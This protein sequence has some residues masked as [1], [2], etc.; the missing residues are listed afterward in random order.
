MI[1]K[2]QAL[3]EMRPLSSNRK[4]LAKIA[5]NQQTNKCLPKLHDFFSLF[6]FFQCTKFEQKGVRVFRRKNTKIVVGK[7]GKLDF[8]GFWDQFMGFVFALF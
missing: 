8:K 1:L 5:S 3:P 4:A 6:D 2:K 7:N